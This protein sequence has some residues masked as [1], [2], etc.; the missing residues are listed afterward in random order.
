MSIVIIL[1]GLPGSGKSSFAKVIEEEAPKDTAIVSADNYF[2]K[3]GIYTFDPTKIGEAHE[4]CRKAFA[5][6]IDK[7]KIVI[8]DNTNTQFW[9]F[10]YYWSVGLPYGHV[11]VV[12]LFDGGR[13]DA[14]LAQRTRHGVPVEK[15]QE[16]RDRFEHDWKNGHQLPPWER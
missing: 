11:R 6:A 8:V 12:S 2:Y 9:E 1:R 7:K 4:Q 10:S 3:G 13:T 15:I 5:S 16:M 14:Q